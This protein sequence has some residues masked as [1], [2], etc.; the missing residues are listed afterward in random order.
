MADPK[1]VKLAA[2]A[3]AVYKAMG[4]T[5]H[6]IH[7]CDDDSGDA[8]KRIENGG[9]RMEL[10]WVDHNEIRKIEDYL[11]ENS[12]FDQYLQQL[13]DPMRTMKRTFLSYEL[14]VVMRV[15]AI[16]RFKAAHAVICP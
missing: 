16:K 5:E 3:N 14:N 12:L 11:Y 9:V 1:I 8:W 15:T 10:P 13:I 7:V 4:L 2:M 6:W